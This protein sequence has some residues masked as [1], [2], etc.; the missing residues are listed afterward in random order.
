MSRSVAALSVLAMALGAASLAA[1]IPA[2]LGNVSDFAGALDGAAEARLERTIERIGAQG[3]KLAVAVVDRTDPE[4]PKG[5]ATAAFNQWGVGDQ[6]KDNGVLVVLAIGNRRVEV[7][8]GYGVEHRLT[9]S[10]VGRLLDAHAV[11]YFRR[12][13]WP[14]GLEALVDGIADHL[15]P[16]P[17]ASRSRPRYTPPPRSYRSSNDDNL[18]GL[19]LAFLVG[20]MVFGTTATNLPM[21]IAGGW[22]FWALTF[23]MRHLF[24]DRRFW[25]AGLVA[26][27]ASIG[28]QMGIR[29]AADW[30]PFPFLSLC[31][32]AIFGLYTEGRRCPRCKVGYT[33][34]RS[35]TLRSATY[36][37]AGRGQT[38]TT[39]PRCSY[40]QVSTYTIP[41]RTRST[42][43]SS[44]SYS[45]SSSWSSS[46]SSYSSFGGGSSGGGGAG[47]S[48]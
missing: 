30:G 28:C 41:R 5:W 22:A 31:L 19:L 38:T 39:C 47:R 27:L 4:T 43:S 12:D 6:G 36:Y 9:D 14:G 10:Q 25:L 48:F 21:L 16:R 40:H 11:P 33:D 35:V 34:V 20:I 18:F 44:S 37:S 15:G 17:E 23:P 29:G 7:E 2:R 26:T 46:S 1:S 3:V 32:G 45:S 42:S 8:T 13:D 24:V